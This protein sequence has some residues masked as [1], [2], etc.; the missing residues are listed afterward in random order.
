MP[1]LCSQNFPLN[2]KYVD[3][4]ICLNNVIFYLWTVVLTTVR[5]PWT[6]LWWKDIIHRNWSG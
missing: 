3:I 1:C 5:S 2:K 4:N 6:V